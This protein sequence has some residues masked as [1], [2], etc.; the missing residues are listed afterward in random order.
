[1]KIRDIMYLLWK[2]LRGEAMG[3]GD[4]FRERR[5]VLGD[6]REKVFNFKE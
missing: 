4:E 3:E 5:Y 1:M 2:G 6:K